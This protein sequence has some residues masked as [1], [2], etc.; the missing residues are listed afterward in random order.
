MIRGWRLNNGP[1]QQTMDAEA[2][3]YLNPSLAWQ[4]LFRNVA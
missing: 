1:V 2:P 3:D 4:G